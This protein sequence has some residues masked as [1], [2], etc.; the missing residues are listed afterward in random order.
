M[1]HA[2]EEREYNKRFDLALWKKLLTFCKPY[3]KKLFLLA[4]FMLSLAG[5]DVLFP[6]MSKYAIDNFVVPKS[7][8]G[9][10]IYALVFLAMVAIQALNI[11]FFINIAGKIEMYLT[12]DIRKKGFLHLQELSFNYYDKTPVGWLM[13]RMTSDSQRLGSFISWGL[14]DMVWGFSMMVLIAV[15]LL[16]MNLKLALITL[17]VVPVLVVMSIYFQ[18]KIL[19]A[20]RK[21]RKTNSKITGAFNEGISGA[22]TTKTLVREAA[23][24]KEFQVHTTDMYSS[25]VR[26]AVF[27]S[28]YLPAILTLG[29]IGT[30]LALWFGGEGVISGVVTYGTLVAFIS[31]SVQFFEPLGEMARVFAELQ[32]AQA[33]AERIF[34]MIDEVP[35][36]KDNSQVTREFGDIM[37]SK[38]EN[39]PDINGDISFEDVTFSYKEG[40]NI[41]EKFQLDIKAGETIALVG[42]TGSGKSTVVNL[43]CRFYEP[44]IGSIKIDGVDYR[45]RSML[46]LH[47]NLGY[48]LQTPHLFSGTIKENIAYGRL[49]A[50]DEEI[51]AAAKLVD[52][53]EFIMNMEKGYDSEV[54][55]GGAK[56]STG[57]K[58]LISFARAILADPRIFVLDEA[59]SSVDTETEQLIQKAI[60]TVLEGRTSFIIAH[61]LSTIRSAD[62]ILVIGNGKITEQGNH[63]ELI[64]QKGNYYNLYTN[65]FM[66]EQ[67]SML[68]NA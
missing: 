12:Y 58:Q 31:Y 67:E 20:Y 19:K 51:I 13:A 60:H 34:S 3:K 6:L 27:S 47:S 40:E 2:F 1:N 30:G 37:N 15:I 42:E 41:L 11:F 26:A 36:I 38:E 52:A 59:T 17:T 10:T 22:K 46:W 32:N 14:V 7:T 24:L 4:F 33:S 45:E 18:K 28:L 66:E 54:G 63:H 44:T 29:S 56:L 5:I 9:I 61:R 23:N 35:Q 55:E 16:V 53:H 50:T 21:V 62:R 57:E 65:Q 25:S 64:K 8:D 43:A 68:L 49:D 39:W 48:V